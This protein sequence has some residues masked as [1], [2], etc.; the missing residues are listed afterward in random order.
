MREEA[1]WRKNEGGSL[2]AEVRSGRSSCDI[3]AAF[4]IRK[5]SHAR[6]LTV[7]ASGSSGSHL[8]DLGRKTQDLGRATTAER[9]YVIR[10][11]T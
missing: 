10:D 8:V 2:V 6:S 11:V 1:F 9:E 7:T 4:D 3:D 5:D